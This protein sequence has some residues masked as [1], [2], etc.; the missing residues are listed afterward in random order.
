MA[1][2]LRLAFQSP[3]EV[4]RFFNI[5]HNGVVRRE[6]FWFCVST[7]NMDL[8]FG[9]ILSFFD[10]LDVNRDGQIDEKEFTSGLYPNGF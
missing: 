4:F 1:A 9:E 7:F 10:S 3:A 5:L 2:K 8:S 6:H